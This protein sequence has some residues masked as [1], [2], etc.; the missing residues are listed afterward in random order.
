MEDSEKPI[1]YKCEHVESGKAGPSFYL[2]AGDSVRFLTCNLCANVIL[3]A[4]ISARIKDGV[5]SRR[6]EASSEN[7]KP[8]QG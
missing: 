8:V 2:W 4:I 1:V 5:G 6:F 3:G 7:V